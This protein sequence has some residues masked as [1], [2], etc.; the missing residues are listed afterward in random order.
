MKS[1]TK[2]EASFS[3]DLGFIWYLQF[4]INI[5]LFANLSAQQMHGAD[6]P[7]I[8]KDLHVLCCFYFA[9]FFFL[10]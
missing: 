7:G 6:L 1:E 9:F 4:H 8:P 10:Q 3:S 5:K 2:Y